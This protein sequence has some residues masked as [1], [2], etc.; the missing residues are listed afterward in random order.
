MSSE[1]DVPA[2][3]LKVRRRLAQMP[4]SFKGPYLRAVH[5]KSRKAAITSFC[6]ECTG[7]SIKDIRYCPDNGCPLWA[8]RPYQE[9]RKR[10][11]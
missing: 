11:P 5:K 10:E 3:R 8:F 1:P 9:V 2:D 4:S 7:W 6:R